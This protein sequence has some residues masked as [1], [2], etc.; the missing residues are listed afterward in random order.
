VLIPAAERRLRVGCMY[1]AL[2]TG[3][4]EFDVYAQVR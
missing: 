2:I 3:A 4:E 1:D